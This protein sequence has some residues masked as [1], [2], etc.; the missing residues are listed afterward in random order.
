MIYNTSLP[1]DKE[2]FLLRAQTLADKGS[3]IELT[4]KVMGTPNQNS[5]LHLLIG[6]VAMY[7][8]TTLEDAK[9]EYF[10]RIANKELFVRVIE[11]K[12]QGVKREILRSTSTL[13]KEEKSLAIDRFKAWARSNNIFLPE[14]GDREI[15]AQIQY[16]M[17]K[18]KAE[19]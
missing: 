1:F 4:E 8:G 15:L 9:A 6:V 5:Y 13:N 17:E 7:V 12:V 16:E 19:L 10:K 2:K 18:N 11:D 14:P 3:I